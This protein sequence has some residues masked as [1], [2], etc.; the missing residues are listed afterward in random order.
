MSCHGLL[1]P[2]DSIRANC[3]PAAGLPYTEQ[4]YSGPFHPAARHHERWNWNC[5]MRA[6][7]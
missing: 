7:K 3:A 6:M 2:A 5:R 4:R 1:A